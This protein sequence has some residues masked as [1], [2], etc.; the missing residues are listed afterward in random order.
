[1]TPSFQLNSQE[2]SWKIFCKNPLLA[3]CIRFKPLYVHACDR[4]ESSWSVT[5]KTIL[6]SF[7]RLKL[8]LRA[9]WAHSQLLH[10]EFLVSVFAFIASPIRIRA[11]H[12]RSVL[13]IFMFRFIAFMVHHVHT[14]K[15]CTFDILFMKLYIRIR[16]EKWYKMY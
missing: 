16:N 4:D 13:S 7:M 14:N 1:M 15:Y 10:E 3:F 2:I 12:H 11:I 5:T 8:I 9:I 6:I